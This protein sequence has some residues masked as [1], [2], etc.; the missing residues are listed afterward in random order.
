M[1]QIFVGACHTGR[2]VSLDVRFGRDDTG[3]AQGRIEVEALAGGQIGATGTVENEVGKHTLVPVVAHGAQDFLRLGGLVATTDDPGALAISQVGL[4]VVLVEVAGPVDAALE[5][6]LHL[7]VGEPVAEFHHLGV[8]A[9]VQLLAQDIILVV[10]GGGGAHQL[11]VA[12]LLGGILTQTANVV[13][14]YAGID[15]EAFHEHTQILT[16]QHVGQHF[17]LGI[18]LLT[19]VLHLGHR[20]DGSVQGRSAVYTVG[21]LHREGGRRKAVQGL[22]N[23]TAVVAF[24]EL[25]Q[26]GHDV[27]LHGG[28]GSDVHVHVGTDA[29]AVVVMVGVVTVVRGGFLIKEVF[30]EVVHGGKVTEVLVSALES[31]LGTVVVSVIPEDLAPPVHVGISV[32]ILAAIEGKQLGIVVLGR[33]T[34]QR[35]GLID[36]EAISI[37]IGKFRSTEH[38]LE[39]V[40]VFGRYL[41]ARI[42][43]ALGGN[44]DDSVGTLH[45][46]QGGGCGIL[47]NGHGLN[48]KAHQVVGLAGEAIHQH[49][50]AVT[51]QTHGEFEL[52]L[53]GVVHTGPRL[54]QESGELPIEGIGN[55]RFGALLKEV[56]AGGKVDVGL[57]PEGIT[58]R[59]RIQHRLLLG[60]CRGAYK[61]KRKYNIFI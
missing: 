58:Q 60:Q 26:A 53:V 38:L 46:V 56:T 36:Q 61:Q 2:S 51:M 18:L 34:V 16:E 29:Q 17:G 9:V 42:L 20:V 52:G 25:G 50:R 37:S 45:T 59:D 41:Q 5:F 12:I 43:T 33:E 44:G 22:L 27:H 49:E 21:L 40:L 35:T 23:T 8:Y 30:L 24:V 6:E 7:Q 1:L 31:E 32:R 39:T 11:G 4:Q 54:D 48:L 13:K 47:E 3:H 19:G 15:G 10:L 28:G 14:G 57:D 55:I